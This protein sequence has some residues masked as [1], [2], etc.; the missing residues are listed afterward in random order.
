LQDE[1][2]HFIL[3]DGRADDIINQSK[4]EGRDSTEKSTGYHG[5][6]QPLHQMVVILIWYLAIR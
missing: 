3:K 1:I 5:L 6:D 4:T 2:E